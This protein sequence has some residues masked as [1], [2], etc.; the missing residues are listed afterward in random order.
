MKFLK[1]LGRFL[2]VIIS[3]F[4]IGVELYLHGVFDFYEKLDKVTSTGELY[5]YTVD[6]LAEG[7][8]EFKIYATNISESDIKKINSEIV[9]FYGSV[10]SYTILNEK[11]D[12]TK[13]LKISLK[14]SGNQN[15]YK[16]LVDNDN[17]SLNE[18]EQAIYDKARE[19]LSETIDDTMSDYEK[20]E[21]IHD[22]IIK[23]CI[24]EKSSEGS[25]SDS[26]IYSP[27]GVLINGAAVC[28][29]YAET[30]YLLLNACKIECKIVVG[31]ADNE[32][33]AWNLVKIDGVWYH[34]DTTWDD[35]VPDQGRNVQYNFFNLTDDAMSETHTWAYERYPKCTDDSNTYFKK[36]KLVCKDYTSFI[37]KT[38]KAINKRQEYISLM[39]PDYKEDDYNLSFI[40][41]SHPEVA[42]ASYSTVDSY[43][44]TTV[45]LFI[46]YND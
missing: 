10:N 45:S 25:Q 42:K 26:D 36:H 4:I 19:V 24:Y 3:L 6:A 20:E 5:E 21:A 16:A 46:T 33:H 23:N 27:Y 14:A 7:K 18:R 2:L 17:I 1:G 32:N 30:M 9:G 35:P 28:N 37:K 40:M 12:G 8:S 15:V 22:Y 34:L 43:M 11:S 41:D 44:G 39:V 13:K 38:N 31:K 29:G